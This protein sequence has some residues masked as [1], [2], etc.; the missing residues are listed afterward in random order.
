[1]LLYQILFYSIHGKIYIYKKS[2]AKTIN[3]KYQLQRGIMNLNCLTD[4]IL[5][6]IIKDISSISLKNMKQ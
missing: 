6:H 1:M 5:Y 2:N 3:L 4:H